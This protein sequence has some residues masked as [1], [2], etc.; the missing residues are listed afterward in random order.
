MPTMRTCS[1]AGKASLRVPTPS[2]ETQRDLA[3]R[4]TEALIAAADV[5]APTADALKDGAPKPPPEARIIPRA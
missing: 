3:R 2:N 1:R 4:F 5:V